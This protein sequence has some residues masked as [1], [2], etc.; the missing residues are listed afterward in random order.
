[1]NDHLTAKTYKLLNWPQLW[2]TLIS[3]SDPLHDQIIQQQ[4]EVKEIRQNISNNEDSI[5]SLSTT[6]DQLVSNHRE[7]SSGMESLQNYLNELSSDSGSAPLTLLKE[8]LGELKLASTLSTDSQQQN[9]EVIEIVDKVLRSVKE[10]IKRTTGRLDDVEEKYENIVK[11]LI[12]MAN[13]H[14][15]FEKSILELQTLKS[16][17]SSKSSSGKSKSNSR[18]SATSSTIQEKPALERSSSGSD[19]GSS[20]NSSGRDKS[21]KYASFGNMNN[22]Y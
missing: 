2:N 1:M 8:R 7:F 17:S 22:F 13:T 6:T 20:S 5:K 12:E 19:N 18:E 16:S 14:I 9:R 10:K 4:K 15:N 21:K 11:Q 3:I